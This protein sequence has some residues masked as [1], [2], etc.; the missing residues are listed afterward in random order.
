MLFYEIL[1]VILTFPLPFNE[2]IQQK[3]SPQFKGRQF[4]HL[5][6]SLWIPLL[7][8]QAQRF[9]NKQGHLAHASGGLDSWLQHTQSHAGHCAWSSHSGEE[10]D[11]C[12]LPS[13]RSRSGRPLFFLPCAAYMGPQQP[14]PTGTVVGLGA[15]RGMPLARTQQVRELWSDSQSFWSICILL[16]INSLFY[17]CGKRNKN[18]VLCGF[19]LFS[20]SGIGVLFGFFYETGITSTW[21]MYPR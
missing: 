14:G 8:R 6:S 16:S 4:S 12:L 3:L 19:C 15:Q 11:Q 20:K 21:A 17:R 5:R 13:G 1:C 9:F 7:L 18:S 2:R 10:R